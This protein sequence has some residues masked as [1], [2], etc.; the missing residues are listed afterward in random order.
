[1][2]FPE[3]PTILRMPSWLGHSIHEEMELPLQPGDYKVTPGQTNAH[4][5]TVTQVKD[6]Q[7]V[8]QGIGPVEVVASPAPF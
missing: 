5:W 8:Y 7:I 3:H 4:R 1:M 6:G 2:L